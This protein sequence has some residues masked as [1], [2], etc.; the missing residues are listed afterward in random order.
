MHYAK[1][2]CFMIAHTRDT[3]RQ[4]TGMTLQQDMCACQRTK[5]CGTWV[6]SKLA[7]LSAHQMGVRSIP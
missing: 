1:D 2:A 4:V 7:L 5:H 3:T 6:A